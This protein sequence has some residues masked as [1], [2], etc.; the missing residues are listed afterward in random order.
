[1]TVV[2]VGSLHLDVV[3]RAPHLPAIDETVAGSGVEYVFGGKGGNQALALSKLGAQVIMAGRAGRDGFGDQIRRTL[4]SVGVDMSLLQL[5][6][7]PSGMSVAII[8]ATGEY[9][10]VIV[11]AANLALEADK[12]KLPADTSLVL[13]Q[14]EIPESVNLAV[15][16]AAKSIGS[17]VWLN[18]AP[19]RPLSDELLSNVDLLIVNRVEAACYTTLSRNVE[20]LTTLGADG[21]QYR[22]S[23]WPA[24]EVEVLSTHGAG[25]MFVGALA[26]RVADGDSVTQAIPFAQTAAAWHISTNRAVRDAQSSG[27]LNALLRHQLKP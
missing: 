5:D 15:A 1:M 18:A 23:T 14:N 7:G 16:Q 2:V 24:P 19:A 20:A 8:D 13:L 26:A 9:G 21:V 17:S 22:S 3:V 27:Q 4:Q 6:D 12:I 25:D 11:S 10:A